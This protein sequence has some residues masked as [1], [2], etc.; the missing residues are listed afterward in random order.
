MDLRIVITDENDEALEDIRVYQDGSDAD[1]AAAIAAFI[2][3]SFD[4]DSDVTGEQRLADSI[5]A[6]L[7]DI[8]RS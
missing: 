2:R 4:I 8:A 1:G 5:R 7:L 3:A 6:T